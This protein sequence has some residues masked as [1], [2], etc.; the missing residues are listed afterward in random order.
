MLKILNW[1]SAVLDRI[2]RIV[3]VPM[4]ASFFL[5]ILLGVFT[6]FVLRRP[7]LGI[8]DY[9]TTSFVWSCFL[10][11]SI[12]FRSKEHIVI[13]GFVNLLPAKVKALVSVLMEVIELAFF[14]FVFLIGI[15]VVGKVHVT[16]MVSTGMPMSMLYSALPVCM[17]TCAIHSSANLM[18]KIFDHKSDSRAAEKGPVL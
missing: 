17:F 15:T 13:A 18:N 11:A 8:S 5:M 3:A 9:S 14:I 7:M 10:G 1:T 16:R 2:S 4:M 6:R 12:L